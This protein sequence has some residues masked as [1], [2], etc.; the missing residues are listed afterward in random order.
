[1]GDGAGCSD[2]PMHPM[3][4]RPGVSFGPFFGPFE[5]KGQ[6][7]GRCWRASRCRVA[8]R[9]NGFRSLDRQI[10]ENARLVQIKTLCFI[11]G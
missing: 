9:S 8:K 10:G 4:R 1:M 6:R 7:C 5:Q 3:H 11:A 2:G